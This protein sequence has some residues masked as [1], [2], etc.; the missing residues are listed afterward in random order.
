[1]CSGIHAWLLTVLTSPARP[2]ARPPPVPGSCPSRIPTPR[3]RTSNACLRK[4]ASSPRT[5]CRGTHARGSLSTSG[6]TRPGTCGRPCGPSRR[7]TCG[8]VT[9]ARMPCWPAMA[10]AITAEDRRSGLGMRTPAEFAGPAGPPSPAHM[11]SGP[12][13]GVR[14]RCRSDAAEPLLLLVRIK[15]RLKLTPGVG[16]G[17][18]TGQCQVR[19]AVRIT[20][21]VTLLGGRALEQARTGPTSTSAAATSVAGG[22]CNMAHTKLTRNRG[23]LLT[24]S[25]YCA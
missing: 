7:C 18:D 23:G 11:A 9:A 19:A 1:M 15:W 24:L 10:I 2:P 12:D 22:H 21:A 16:W 20:K 5:R 6:R 8:G 3:L 17:S 14:S 25:G 13:A 4:R